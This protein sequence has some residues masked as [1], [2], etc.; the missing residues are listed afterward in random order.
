[1]EVLAA[2]ACVDYVVAFGGPTPRRLI[3]RLTPDILVKGA[4]W[5][6]GEIVGREIVEQ[7]GGRVARIRMVPGVSTTELVKRIV[8]SAKK[9]PLR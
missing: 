4:D 8:D 1:M 6:L 7:Y 2:L 9:I 5:V 3:E